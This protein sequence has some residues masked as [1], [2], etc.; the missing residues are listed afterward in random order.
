M[1]GRT[2]GLIS[3][4]E[5]LDMMQELL[6]LR[7]VRSLKSLE[8]LAE[9]YPKECASTLAKEQKWQ[10]NTRRFQDCTKPLRCDADAGTFHR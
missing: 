1:Y 10:E 8:L 5:G 3:G 9:P 7:R 6:M 4:F 2:I